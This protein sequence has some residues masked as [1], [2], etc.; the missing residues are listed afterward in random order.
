MPEQHLF[1]PGAYPGTSREGDSLLARFWRLKDRITGGIG[2]GQPRGPLEDSV[3]LEAVPSE[4]K[5]RLHD[6]FQRL[7][8]PGVP[9]DPRAY[10]DLVAAFRDMARSLR[11]AGAEG[12]DPDAPD[13]DPP[14]S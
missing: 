13:E 11:D 14:P 3:G 8:R 12:L 7:T 4:V 9:E 5:L 1:P 6:A 2:R 10:R